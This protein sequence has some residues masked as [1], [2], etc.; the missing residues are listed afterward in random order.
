MT[1]GGAGTAPTHD[2][3]R[4]SAWI[5]RFAPL[6]VAGGAVLDV[7]CG[8]GRHVRWFE[9]HGHRVTAID[10]S[11]TA[12]AAASASEP[13]LADLEA[14][15]AARCWPVAG[16]RFAAVVVTNY[17]HRPLLPLL[18][19]ALAPGGVLLYETFAAGNARFGRPASPAFL[20]EPGELLAATAGL[21]VVAYENGVVRHPR[22]ASIQRIC[23]VRDATA[24]TTADVLE[25]GIQAPSDARHAL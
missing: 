18:V 9:A 6:V 20:L 13:L 11:A 4:P 16:R 25:G 17:L 24:H 1:G 19:A 5:V 8:S 10:R 22:P 15:D 2:H 3:D 21:T 23:A 12:L 14:G 7:A